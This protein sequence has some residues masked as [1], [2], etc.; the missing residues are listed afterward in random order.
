MRQIQNLNINNTY[1]SLNLN[2]TLG[3]DPNKVRKV[4]AVNKQQILT[5]IK[6][7]QYADRYILFHTRA[8]RSLGED[9]KLNR[10]ILRTPRPVSYYTTNVVPIHILLRLADKKDCEVVYNIAKEF[11]LE[12][13]KN[14][15]T[16]N[17]LCRTVVSCPLV[18]PD[19]NY[20]DILFSLWDLRYIL[21]RVKLEFPDLTKKQIGDRVNYY[22]Y[23]KIT[24]LY[25][26]R[27]RYKYQYYQD[28]HEVLAR[29]R[30]Q[31][32]LLLNSLDECAYIEKK[33]LKH[34]V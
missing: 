5:D 30:I 32:W 34:K 7:K 11:T 12:Q 3:Y 29:W 10:A 18:F 16:A 27:K 9:D 13:I 6:H 25:Q 26:L 24:Q 14:I 1:R 21:D 19:V 22:E 20:R 15:E 28:L 31:L 33:A 4:T 8:A 23:N 17:M 2:T